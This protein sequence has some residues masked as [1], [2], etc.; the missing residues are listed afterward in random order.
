MKNKNRKM[1]WIFAAVLLIAAIVVFLLLNQSDSSKGIAYIQKQEELKVDDIQDTLLKKKQAERKEAIA[2]GKLD[3]F[4]LVDD[5]VF[6]GDSRVMGYDVYGLLDANRI[7]AGT[8]YTFK[9]VEEWDESLKNLN[10]SYVFI[11][12]GINDLGLKLDEVYEYGYDGLAKEKMNHILEI[13]PN[14]KIYL[15]SII[16]CSPSVTQEHPAWANYKNYNEKLKKACSAIENCTYVDTAPLADEGNANIYSGDG[17]HFTKS[18]Y[19]DWLNAIVD[20][21]DN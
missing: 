20:S 1:V 12:Y 6:Y 21:M 15:C 8:G 14:A 7:F 18:F 11:S 2:Q 4:S 5:F 17:I 9:N 19:T 16:P 10:P 13:V 3:V